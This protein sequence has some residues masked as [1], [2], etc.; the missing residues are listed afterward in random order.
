M[1]E[2]AQQIDLLCPLTDLCVAPILQWVCVNYSWL[3][4]TTDTIISAQVSI[5]NA[6]LLRDRS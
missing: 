1:Q 4:F 5:P 2:Q 3:A 6:L